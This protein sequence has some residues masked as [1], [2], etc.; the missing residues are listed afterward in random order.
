MNLTAFGPSHRPYS[1]TIHNRQAKYI[2][3]SGLYMRKKK[4]YPVHFTGQRGQQEAS[5]TF[6][7]NETST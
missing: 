2:L 6:Q 3:L 5:E 1:A 7:Q 4:I